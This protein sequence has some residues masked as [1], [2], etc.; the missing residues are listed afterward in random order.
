[1]S[2]TFIIQVNDGVLKDAFSNRE[3]A[4]EYIEQVVIPYWTKQSGGTFEHLDADHWYRNA[5]F[6][7]IAIEKLEVRA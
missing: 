2:Q 3:A 5:P 4:V 6:M 1:M 7:R